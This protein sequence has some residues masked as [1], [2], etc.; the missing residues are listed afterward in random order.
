M[1]L[2]DLISAPPG[3]LVYH[4]VTLFAAQAILG[5]ALDQGRRSG[6]D[7]WKRMGYG[8]FALLVTRL[9]LLFAGVATAAGLLNAQ[10]VVP[11]LE[12][13]LDLAGTAFVLYAFIPRGHVAGQATRSL[14]LISL[15][16]GVVVYAMFAPLWYSAINRSPMLHYNGHWQDLVWS[17][18]QIALL[19][20]GLLVARHGSLI[21]RRLLST[22]LAVLLGGRLLHVVLLSGPPHMA[23]WGRLATLIAL[24]LLAAATY[25]AII[26]GLVDRAAESERERW[27]ATGQLR[28]AQKLTDV[29]ER[30]ALASDLP[31][32]L[33]RATQGVVKVL[34]ASL[35]AIVL[36]RPDNPETVELAAIRRLDGSYETDR[37]CY[38]LQSLPVIRHALTRQK[39]VAV[40]GNADDTG[41]WRGFVAALG[42]RPDEPLSISPLAAGDQAVGVLI[43]ADTPTEW[44]V[45]QV[46]GNGRALTGV[47]GAAIGHAMR[48]QPWGIDYQALAACV[49]PVRAEAESEAMAAWDGDSQATG[50]AGIEDTQRQARFLEETTPAFQREPAERSRKPDERTDRGMR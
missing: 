50:E 3:G 8:L 49:A 37:G 44:I 10:A 39:Q 42:V 48:A 35:C 6:Q 32:A 24:P 41:A 11:P 2:L 7:D 27:T 40:N 23:A 31:T 29:V 12:R 18:W 21:D 25:R 28:E 46:Q 17:A 33:Q 43:V 47:I 5:M 34:D 26:E 45:P 22:A 14:C 38:D 30:I 15:A 36:V 16:L 19:L 4:L 9:V 1:N 20:W 13:F